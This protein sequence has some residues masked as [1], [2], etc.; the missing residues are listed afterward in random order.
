VGVDPISLGI[1]EAPGNYGADIV[2]GEGQPLGNYANYGG[3]LLGILACRGDMRLVRQMPGR[4]VGLTQSI[5]GR[6]GFCMALQTREQHIR[7][8]R[9][10]SN[11][12]TNEALC[13]VA[14]AT[15]LAL[16]GPRGLRELGECVAYRCNYAIKL[17]SKIEGIKAPVF[18]SFHFKEF[19]IN[20]DRTDRSVEEVHDSLL[21]KGI[22]GGKPIK[23]EFPELGEMALYCVTEIHSKED[24]DRLFHALR[25]VMEG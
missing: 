17:L 4:M 2:I 9:A 25:E 19:T 8:E 13:A 7:R 14:A 11:I 24:I 10:S 16:L 15:Y 6:R 18:D 20:F 3:P 22:H 5:N 23:G 1:L 21:S 12:C